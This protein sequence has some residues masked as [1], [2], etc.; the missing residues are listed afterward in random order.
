[1]G[2]ASKDRDIGGGGLDRSN[3]GCRSQLEEVENSLEHDHWPDRRGG[4]VRAG[5]EH[6]GVAQVGAGEVRQD[7]P[8]R[9]QSIP[10][11]EKQDQSSEI[12]NRNL[13]RSVR[14][15]GILYSS[16]FLLC[17]LQGRGS[18]FFQ[19]IRVQIYFFRESV[20]G[21]RE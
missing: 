3:R 21:R 16:L 20:P 13:Q 12:R 4:Q 5:G 2:N 15:R 17:A 8:G 1:M 9:E 11:N 18:L 6:E 14:G 19:K 7:H 10:A